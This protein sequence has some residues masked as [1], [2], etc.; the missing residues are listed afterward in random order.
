MNAQA[1][2][3]ITDDETELF[4]LLRQLD[5]A[6]EAS[7]RA[8]ASALGVS[9]GLLNN[10]L[11]AAEKAGFISITERAGPDKRQ[12]FAYA[13]TT[14]GGAEKNRLTD[15]F[16]AKKFAEFNALHAELTG[17][18]SK[19]VPNLS[20]TISMQ[21][22]NHAPIPELYVSYESAQKMKKEAADLQSWDLSPRQICDLELLMNGGFNPLA[23][24]AG[25]RT[26]RASDNAFYIGQLDTVIR[27]SR[28]HTVWFDTQTD[29]PRYL[30]PVLEPDATA[31]PS[32][33][34]IV[35]DFRG[36]DGFD[37]G[38]EM[39]P[40]DS[41]TV[42]PYGDVIQRRSANAPPIKVPV[43]YT[44]GGPEWASTIQSV[45][46]ARFLQMRLT[47]VSDIASGVTPELDAI[48]IAFEER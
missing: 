8:T 1:N 5:A 6:P 23:T 24:P 46:G 44:L 37:P 21:I 13:L 31:Q 39:R 16:L 32:G 45:D 42:D 11:K 29:T 40:F 15:R 4:R 25:R 18:T 47:F 3:P 22:P 30:T 9:L 38:A 27:V 12:R 10:R 43:Q 2:Q 35:V 28:A 36:A 20:R 19:L 7:Q 34:E 48:G 33:T 14:R 26:K 17:S 41:V